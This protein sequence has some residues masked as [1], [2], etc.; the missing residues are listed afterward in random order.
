MILLPLISHQDNTRC[1]TMCFQV[2]HVYMPWQQ[3][4][5]RTYLHGN[6]SHMVSAWH[7]FPCPPRL[8]SMCHLIVNPICFPNV[9]YDVPTVLTYH[10]HSI[11]K[12]IPC[13]PY[14]CFATCALWRS[15][16]SHVSSTFVLEFYL[17]ISFVTHSLWCSHSFP[18][19]HLSFNCIPCMICNMFLMMFPKFPFV[20]HLFSLI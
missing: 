17:N 13:I 18:W 7:M 4:A 2:A 9:P 5:P 16:T 15:H 20:I 10:P 19:S 1:D 6:L 11:F 14:I 8:F 12:C 3:F